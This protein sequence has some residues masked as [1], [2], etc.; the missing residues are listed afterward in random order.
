MDGLISIQFVMKEELDIPL[1]LI[2]M[3]RF[4]IQ[5]KLGPFCRS[6][7]DCAIIL[8]NIRGKDPDDISS[9]DIPFGDPFEV[10]LTKLTVGY[11]NDS[12]K[13]VFLLLT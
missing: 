8:D 2:L 3:S 11:L 5:D 1:T 13:E 6:A 10:D 7:E 9:R 12:E 4:L